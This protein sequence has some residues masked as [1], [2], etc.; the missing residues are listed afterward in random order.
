MLE[1][2]ENKGLIRVK[3]QVFD[4]KVD[5][6]NCMILMGLPRALKNTSLKSSIAIQGII[7]CQH[8]L[9]QLILL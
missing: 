8:S 3:R 4:S 5:I 7:L 9:E 1:A 2:A 6:G